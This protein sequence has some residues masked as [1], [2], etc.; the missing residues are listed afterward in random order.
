MSTP[1]T[2]REALCH[3]IMGT[4][5]PHNIKR[6]LERPPKCIENWGIRR[7]EPEWVGNCAILKPY[8]SPETLTAIHYII[9]SLITCFVSGRIDWTPRVRDLQDQR[10]EI[11]FVDEYGWCK[12]SSSEGGRLLQIFG[13]RIKSSLWKQFRSMK[14]Y[15]VEVASDDVIQEKVEERQ[16]RLVINMYIDA[17]MST[18]NLDN[19]KIMY[20]LREVNKEIKRLL[21]DEPDILWLVMFENPTNTTIQV[22]N[23]L[24]SY[25]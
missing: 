12:N 1:E 25:I 18:W 8:L 21:D 24:K 16:R 14:D 17:F 5:D 20:R 10:P 9:H 4:F 6:G 23:M 19:L 7:Q 3:D 13:P 22:T 2:L 11:L 15:S